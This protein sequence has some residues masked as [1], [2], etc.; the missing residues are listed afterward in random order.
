M[1]SNVLESPSKDCFSFSDQPLSYDMAEMNEISNQNNL[2]YIF[3]SYY[4]SVSR[5]NTGYE[6]SEDCKNLSFSELF[7]QELFSSQENK[8]C[9]ITIKIEKEDESLQPCYS[10]VNTQGTTTDS[11]PLIQIEENVPSSSLAYCFAPERSINRTSTKTTDNC[12]VQHL[13]YSPFCETED[14]SIDQ[15]LAKIEL[16]FVKR[17]P[18]DVSDDTVE[19]NIVGM[20]IKP[21]DSNDSQN[22]T[23]NGLGF[24]KVEGN[25][26]SLLSKSSATK[27]RGINRTFIKKKKKSGIQKF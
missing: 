21:F 18:D 12:D 26:L 6:F 13:V 17:E 10:T 11:H 2:D 22:N 20:E 5:Y 9:K 24:V 3:D 14:L 16:P 8:D 15:P 25:S 27:R 4:S 7:D 23:A 19:Q 1:Y